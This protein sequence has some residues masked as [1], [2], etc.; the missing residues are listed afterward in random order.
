MLRATALKISEVLL[1]TEGGEVT[2]TRETGCF[3]DIKSPKCSR[4]KHKHDTLQLSPGGE[5][6][7]SLK[8]QWFGFCSLVQMMNSGTKSFNYWQ[9]AL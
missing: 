4:T 2:V 3:I 7:S 8:A 1:K 5:M 9:I 6:G